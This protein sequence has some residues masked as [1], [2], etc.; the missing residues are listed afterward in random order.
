MPELR[1]KERKKQIGSPMQSKWCETIVFNAFNRMKTKAFKT[2]HDEIGVGVKIQYI[3]FCFTFK[4]IPNRN[5]LKTELSLHLKAKHDLPALLLQKR[6]EKQRER[7]W[8]WFHLMVTRNQINAS[9]SFVEHSNAMCRFFFIVL[10]QIIC[11]HCKVVKELHRVA[12]HW[13]CAGFIFVV[14]CRS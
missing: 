5:M 3:R 14:V 12:L 7:L 6:K 1:I 4:N 2:H 8:I 9:I 10:V 13:L 11:Q